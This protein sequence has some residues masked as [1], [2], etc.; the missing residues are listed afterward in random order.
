[1]FILLVE[2]VVKAV[3]WLKDGLAV[4]DPK[5]QQLESGLKLKVNNVQTEDGGVYQCFVT[6]DNGKQLQS[7]G[8]LRLGGKN[9]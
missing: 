1:M 3:K 4:T 9:F 2:N 8:E 7:S 6:F 5:Y